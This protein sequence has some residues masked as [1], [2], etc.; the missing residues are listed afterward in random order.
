M[1][2]SSVSITSL[3]KLAKPIYLEHYAKWPK[4]LGWPGVPPAL[5]GLAL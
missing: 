3:F 4:V 1:G 5:E 2:F